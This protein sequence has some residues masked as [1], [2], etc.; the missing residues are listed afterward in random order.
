MAIVVITGDIG[1]GKSTAAKLLAEKISCPLIDADK[2]TAELWHDEEVKKIFV[3]RWGNEILDSSGEIIKSEISRRIFSDVNEYKFCNSIL[4]PLIMKEL[5]AKGEGSKI[6]NK[7]LILE[8]PLLFEASEIRPAWI[9]K[10]IYIAASFEV[11]AKRCF[12]QRGW[13]V[14]ELKRRES[15]LMPSDKK[16]LLSDF[17]IYNNGDLEELKRDYNLTI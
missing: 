4:H 14:D 10:I 7:N 15:F 5:E 6:K 2:I 16:N 13:S 3:A 17:T 9:D 11:R 8:I 1:A 12:K